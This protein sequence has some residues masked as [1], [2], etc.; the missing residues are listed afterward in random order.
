MLEV[1]AAGALAGLPTNGPDIVQVARTYFGPLS[2]DPSRALGFAP[3]GE[4]TILDTQLAA[5]ARARRYIYIEDQYLTPPLEY[6]NALIAAAARVSGPL[7][8]VIPETPDQPF[9]FEARQRFVA[10]LQAAW[11]DRLKVGTMRGRFSRTQTN[12]K[13]AVGRLWLEEDVADGDT[14]IVVG[15]P[16]RVPGTPFWLIVDNE[17]MRVIGKAA[18]TGTEETIRLRVDRGNIT[19]LFGAGKG[20][21]TSGHKAYTPATSG[22]FAGIYVHSKIM[23]VDDCFASIGSAN[24]NRRGY[25]SDGECNIFTLREDLTHGENWIRT[26]RTRLW[27]ELTDVSDEFGAV[28]FADPSRNLDLFD[29]KF[30]TGNRFSPFSAQP[31][32]VAM[33][34]ETDFTGGS[35]LTGVGFILKAAASIGQIIAG[36]SSEA[37]FDSFIDPS[38]E[39]AP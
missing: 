15:P 37:L 29:R 39:V 18:A 30:L 28:A 35:A 33:E 11:G 22:I 8:I 12:R 3:N 23:L 4:R 5:I 7:I 25:Y 17:P 19:N 27:S 14:E 10:D 38:S 31:Y 26:L 32:T 1:D 9:G 13:T 24:C 2:T 20:P 21:K 6:R 16:A 36:T 34:I